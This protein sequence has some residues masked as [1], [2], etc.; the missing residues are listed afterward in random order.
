MRSVAEKMGLLR[1]MR[2]GLH[3]GDDEL[4]AVAAAVDVCEVQA[5]EVLVGEHAPSRQSFVVLEGVA[6]MHS[7]GA[8][9]AL[10]GPGSYIDALGADERPV[11]ATAQTDMVVLVISPS[12][13]ERFGLGQRLL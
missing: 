2:T 11:G 8:A 9:V 10:V 5:G 6:S 3:L 12:V 7:G 1:S 4:R 13:A